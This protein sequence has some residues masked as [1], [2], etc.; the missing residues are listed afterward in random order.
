MKKIIEFLKGLNIDWNTVLTIFAILVGS[1]IITKLV[2]WVITKTFINASEKINVDPTRYKFLKNAA[3]LVILIIALGAIVLMIPKLKALAITL[4]AGAGILMVFIGLAA[5]Q[6]FSNIVGG[7]FI[8]IFKPIRI[9]DLIKV[10]SLDY[11]VVEDI[12][13]RHTVII[14]FENKRIIIPNSVIS[15]DVIINDSIDDSNICR[16]ITIG[17][18]YD[19]DIQLATRIMQEESI[20]HPNCI[21]ARTEEQ[22]KD[23]VPQVQVSV[24][25]FGDFSVDLRADVWTDDPFK[26]RQMHYEI[27]KA[28]KKRFDAEGV[29]I[30]FPYRTVVYKKDLPSNKKL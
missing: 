3:S 15:T 17:I 7:I 29:E 24:I 28:V 1:I 10:G 2:R 25:N 21:D 19:S 30:P 9:G 27:N 5:Q 26:A 12:T 6:A 22:L 20:K 13:L 16:R 8:V 23:K 11:G 14:N 18:S 4:F